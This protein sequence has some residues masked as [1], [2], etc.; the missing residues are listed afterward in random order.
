MKYENAVYPNEEQI[1]GFLEPGA[2]GPIGMVNLLKFK[3]KAE[4]E[5]GRAT[6]LTGRQAYEIYE[7]GVRKLLE[8]VGGSLSFWGDTSRLAIGEVE[9]LWDLVGIAIWPSR[10]V[11]FETMM[12]ERM[13]QISV[14]RSAGLSGQLNIETTNIAG[15]WLPNQAEKV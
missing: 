15:D 3:P 12:S 2:D 13:Q 11:M 7:E 9:E 4:Y 1:K 14:H 6:D 8:E 10:K 5:D